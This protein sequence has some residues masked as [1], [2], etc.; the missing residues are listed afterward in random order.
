VTAS[1]DVR[2]T[3]EEAFK[4]LPDSWNRKDCILVDTY[5]EPYRAEIGKTAYEDCWTF[6]FLA[7]PELSHVS[8]TQL[9]SALE[10]L[11]I[12]GCYM[13][14]QCHVNVCTG[15]VSGGEW[16]YSKHLIHEYNSRHMLLK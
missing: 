15:E 3:A 4:L 14:M 1:A 6:R 12:A 13:E 8:N 10:V 7:P 5:L 11:G 9:G 2:Y 16:K